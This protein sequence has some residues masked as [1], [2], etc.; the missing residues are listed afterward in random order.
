MSFND[1]EKER[2]RYHLGYLNTAPAASVI[3]GMPRATQPSFLVEQAM[4]Y[5]L[6]EAELRVRQHL[7]ILDGLEGKMV[8]A[9]ERL[10]AS[11]VGEITLNP[12]EGELLRREYRVWQCKLAAQLGCYPNPYDPS[13]ND[14]NAN[15]TGGINSPVIGG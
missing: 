8:E 15:G 10:A 7:S 6:P 4:N 13:S 11:K 3:M 1:H 9:I 14:G 2:V 12:E 5:I